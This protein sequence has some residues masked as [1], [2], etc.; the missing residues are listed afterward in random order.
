MLI[1]PQHLVKCHI[2]RFSSVLTHADLIPEAA[3]PFPILTAIP[4]SPPGSLTAILSRAPQI[5]TAFYQMRIS[6]QELHRSE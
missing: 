3:S 4:H 6:T 5:Q 1:L 2:C